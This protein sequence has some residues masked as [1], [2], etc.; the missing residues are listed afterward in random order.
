M[1]STS[2]ARTRTGSARGHGTRQKNVESASERADELER[3]SFG[4]RGDSSVEHSDRQPSSE[5][6]DSE[7]FVVVLAESVIPTN[8]TGGSASFRD[9]PLPGWSPSHHEEP[10]TTPPP[11]EYCPVSTYRSARD[12]APRSPFMTFIRPDRPRISI[13][14]TRVDSASAYLSSCRNSSP[15]TILK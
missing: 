13:A 2:W 12:R 11:L 4:H 3:L 6:R 15:R 8:E 5:K 10:S 7:G 9:V 14:S 1:S